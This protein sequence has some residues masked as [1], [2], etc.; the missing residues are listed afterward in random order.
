MSFKHAYALSGGIAT[1]KSTACSLLKIHGFSIIDA[2]IIAREELEKS[3]EEIRELFGAEVF[4]GGNVDRAKLA[5][6]IFDSTQD[7]EKLN[8]LLHPKIQQRIE[9]LAKSLDEKGVPY[10]MDIPLFFE[11]GK[12]SC[13]KTIVVYAPKDIQLERLV[14]RENFSLEEAT[15][16]VNAQMSIEEK[17][18]KA[19][20]IIDNSKDLKH[21]QR[22]V[23]KFVEY[24]RG[25]YENIKI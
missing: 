8:A 9:T 20:W 23:E 4:Q 10:I 16:R 18:A 13:K 21:L 11:S 22:E 3:K 1:G 14:K 17:R 19:D 2:D 15:K 25:E 24:V 7:R 12:Y 6:V 5:S